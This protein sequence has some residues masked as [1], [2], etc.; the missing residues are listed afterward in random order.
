M[1][2]RNKSEKIITNIRRKIEERMFKLGEKE[3]ELRNQFNVQLIRPEILLTERNTTRTSLLE[4]IHETKYG[5]VW[6]S[7]PRCTVLS[8]PKR[9]KNKYQRSVMAHI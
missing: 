8:I 6:K 4:F 3:E 1:A 9:T 2:Q 7:S 5:K